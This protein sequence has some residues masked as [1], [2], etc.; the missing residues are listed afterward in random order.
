MVTYSGV[1]MS[2][3]HIIMTF[4]STQPQPTFTLEPT[5]LKRW[6]VKDYHRMSELGIL[7]PNERTKLIA[8]QITLMAFSEPEPDLFQRTKPDFISDPDNLP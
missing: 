4:L 5:S 3:V 1:Q 7:E 2:K 8:G 6:T